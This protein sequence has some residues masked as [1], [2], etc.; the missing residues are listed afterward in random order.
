MAQALAEKLKHTEPA[1]KERKASV[2]QREQLART[3]ESLLP[4]EKQTA[5]SV[6]APDLKMRKSQSERKPQRERM[7]SEREHGEE[8]MDSAVKENRFQE[9]EGRQ[10]KK[11]SPGEVKGSMSE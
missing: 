8:K 2:P 10:G 4:K 7:G 11:A 3:P 1:E 5:L 9:E 6:Q